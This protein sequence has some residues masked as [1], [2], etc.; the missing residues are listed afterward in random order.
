[1]ARQN[2]KPAPFERTTRVDNVARQTTG[3]AGVVGLIDYFP[4]LRGDAVGGQL[5]YDVTLNHMPKPLRNSVMANVQAWFVPHSALPRFQSY[6]EFMHAYQQES[7]EYANATTGAHVTRTP[8]PLFTR[9]NEVSAQANAIRASQHYEMLGLQL[10]IATAGAYINDMIFDAYSMVWNFRAQAHSNRIPLRDTFLA[11]TAL[12]TVFARAFWPQNRFSRVVPD[13]EQALVVGDLALDVVAGQLPVMNMWRRNSGTAAD[14]TNV[15]A[16][17]VVTTRASLIELGYVNTATTPHT[18][19]LLRVQG[20]R[21]SPA[22][23]AVNT[24]T[25]VYAEMAGNTFNV[26][27]ADI[28]KARQTQ[29]FAKYRTSLHGNNPTGYINDDAIMAELMQGFSVPWDEYDRPVLIGSQ[30]SRFQMM[31]R[32]AT[33]GP[34]LDLSTSRG[35]VQGRIP[36]NV[37]QNDIGGVVIVTLEVLP[38]RIYERQYDPYLGVTDAFGLPDALRDIRR[39]EPVDVVQNK[40]LDVAHST[41]NGIYGYE[42][43]NDKWNREFTFLGGEFHQ[44]VPSS[45]WTETRSALWIPEISNPTYTVDHFLAPANFPHDVFSDETKP[46]FEVTVARTCVI[47]GLTQFGD[48]LVEDNDDFAAVAT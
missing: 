28:D 25:D 30:M 46:A 40:R 32:P 47:R 26:T 6:S 16:Q 35:R 34:S 37:P 39:T 20:S 17:D 4:V 29:A 8:A 15:S 11:N 48:P 36:V 13:Y 14:L 12:A 38:E 7:I 3:R 23:P 24:L 42:P 41:P 18:Q 10:P 21:A 5:A 27:L 33:D 43:M 22:D 1:M 19:D 45:D 31:E 9:I 44:S 2:Q